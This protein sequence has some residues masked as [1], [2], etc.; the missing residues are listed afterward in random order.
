MNEIATI[1]QNTVLALPGQVTA[2]GA[3]FPANLSF[4]EWEA[5]GERMR[6]FRESL[7]FIIGDWINYGEAAY[8]EAYAQAIEATDFDY[9]YLRNIA[10]VC[11][12][13]TMSL[14]SDKL[15]FYHHQIV[16]PLEPEDQT[17][18]LDQA[19]KQHWSGAELARAIKLAQ[20]LKDDQPESDDDKEEIFQVTVT[21]ESTW[22]GLVTS[23]TDDIEKNALAEACKQ[24]DENDDVRVIW[25][26]AQ[27]DA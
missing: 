14:R 20:E 3:V 6:G 1:P 13:V 2:I 27:N 25:Q 17:F 7:K 23:T 4:N 8:G 5:C 12:K 16:A 21:I 24:I 10:W 18:W 22:K 19:I 15:T 9:D 11:R 26:L